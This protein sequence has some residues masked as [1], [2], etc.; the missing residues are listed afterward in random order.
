MVGRGG[1]S[2]R[3]VPARGQRSRAGRSAARPAASARPARP[4][5]GQL[6]W[7]LPRAPRTCRG[8]L[9]EDGRRLRAR[10]AAQVAPV[11]LGLPLRRLLLDADAAVLLLAAEAQQAGLLDLLL[12]ALGLVLGW[13]HDHGRLLLLLLV[14]EGGLGPE[15]A[16]LGHGA[17]LPGSGG[18]RPPRAAPGQGAASCDGPGQAQ[19]GAP[20][21]APGWRRRAWVWRR[22]RW[23]AAGDCYWRTGHRPLDCQQARGCAA[24]GAVIGGS[25]DVGERVNAEQAARAPGWWSAGGA[26][27]RSCVSGAAA[28]PNGLQRPVDPLHVA[29]APRFC[30]RRRKGRQTARMA[31][32]AAL[33]LQ[34]KIDRTCAASA[35]NEQRISGAGPAPSSPGHPLSQLAPLRRPSVRLAASTGSAS[36]SPSTA[37]PAPRRRAAQRWRRR[38]ARATRWSRRR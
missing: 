23:R 35:P 28:R 5:P 29:G 3:T 6:P 2:D 9:R 15:V 16:L 22:V 25:D 34:H 13:P 33:L 4:A 24:A 30:L 20:L 11:E 17:P 26:C 7:R 36:R 38:P 1:W 19:P 10:A 27:S 21:A 14:R 12:V 18:T 37:R 31:T 8:A 32:A